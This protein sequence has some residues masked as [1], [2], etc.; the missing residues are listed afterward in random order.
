MWY[1]MNGN[2][3]KSARIKKAYEIHLWKTCSLSCDTPVIKVIQFVLVAVALADI[4]MSKRGH[5]LGTYKTN[6]IHAR[7][8][9]PDLVASGGEPPNISSTQ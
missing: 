4:S 3:C 1:T 2:V 9:Q 7:L 8:I 5:V 6:G